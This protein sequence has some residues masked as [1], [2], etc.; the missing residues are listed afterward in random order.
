MRVHPS[1]LRSSRRLWLFAPV[2]GACSLGIFQLSLSR[3]SFPGYSAALIAQ[4][5]GLVPPSGAAHPVFSLLARQVAALDVL[6]LP[7]RLNFF[8][9]LCGSLCA[10]LLCFLVAKLVLYA[11]SEDGGGGARN[12]LMDADVAVPA[13]QPEVV[14]YNRRVFKIALAG[15]FVAA[16][17]LTF[18]TPTWSAST[19]LES[20]MF[21]L[22]LA[23]AAIN[24][25]P[26]LESDAKFQRLSLMVF[27]VALG[28]A[29]TAAFLLLLPFFAYWVFHIF[30]QT[31]RRSV[32]VKC[33]L[34]AGVA[35]VALAV[36]ACWSNTGTPFSNRGLR[37]VLASL[38]RGFAYHHWD[39]LQ[40]FFPRSGW[41]LVSIQVM[42]PAA[43]LLFGQEL[44]F[45]QRRARTL[46][47]LFL[48]ALM[49]LPTLLNLSIA[50][51]LVFQHT[52][53]LP[54]FGA[55]LVAAAVA[56]SAA[57]CLVF[58]GPN[59]MLNDVDLSLKRDVKLQRRFMVMH[60]IACGL[61]PVILLLALVVPW[62]SFRA[63]DARRG[64]FA[65]MFARELL[66][67]MNGR[68]WLVSNGYLD[69][70]L[71]VQADML[72]QPLVLVTLRRQESQRDREPLK[73]H[74]AA[75]PLFN[76]HN[77]QRL[78]NA[79]SIGTVRFLM[80]WF[81]TDADAGRNAMV[82]TTPD[83]WTA[84]GYRAVP[85]GLAFGGI[86]SEQSPEL[87]G[88]V[89]KNKAF[90]ARLLPFLERQGTEASYLTA[91][92]EML[93][94]KAGLAVNELG[95]LL[96]EANESES[97]YQA[98]GRANQIDPLNISA[99]I[100]VYALVA[101]KK[102]HPEML[103]VLKKRVRTVLSGRKYQTQG[104]VGIVQNYG[105]VRQKAFYRQQ[106]A[107]WL[108][109]GSSEVAVEKNK[110]ALALSEQTGAAAMV[111]NASFYFQAGDSDKAES[112]YLSALE[113]DAS[114]KEALAGISMLMALKQ[115]AQMAE[116]WLKRALAAGVD[117]DAVLY[118]T[119]KLALLKADTALA[120]RMLKEATAK[121]PA[122]FRYWYLYADI[123]LRQGD[124]QALE[125]E[126]LPSMQEAL[127]NPNHFVIQ[128][129]RGFL[130]RSKGPK[131]YKEAR[132]SLF[133]AL[134]ANAA[135]PDVWNAILEI[136]MALNDLT[137]MEADSQKLL[138]TEADHA[139]AN[140]L[141]GAALIRRGALKESE[142]FLRRSIETLPTAVAY[143]DLAENLRLQTKPWEAERAA[144]Q[145]LSLTPNL[146]PALD[147]L[148]GVLLDLGKCEESAQLAARAVAARPNYMPY[149]LTLLRAEVR[150][151]R[152]D[153]VRQRMKL[154]EQAKFAIPEDLK[155]EVAALK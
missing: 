101:V 149:Q 114:N 29:D 139:L 13:L 19:R 93:R 145:A 100:N 123:L 39:E 132:L 154:F 146:L 50:P 151:G 17:L 24:L 81:K 70:H 140:Y 2:A 122:D 84:C 6:S 113:I 83:L 36:Y 143:N 16:Y 138:M 57:A 88:I 119:I 18:L 7:V 68:T 35:G 126:V 74:I 43:V 82:F 26:R 109:R 108:T 125:F 31:E 75:D 103:D 71:V 44:L 127:K 3:G 89:E 115:D 63:V 105:T 91:L 14:I 54:V 59:D 96:D 99:A 49:G 147:T 56:F 25:C 48:A 85:E 144:R 112:C 1:V 52:D 111:E 40:G 4:A 76:G 11:A 152:K 22:L 45:K 124:K 77:R 34:L 130:L 87:K 32:L 41:L 128:A 136:D 92:R 37:S 148:A 80:E 150:L 120:L 72:K 134:S 67:A 12:D 133:R 118:Q 107:L 64:A 97:A 73:R 58:T 131:F 141:M 30:W 38:A 55:A 104:A 23:L 155:K 47:A 8:A 9:A 153:K 27:L 10:M 142:D 86:R 121:F 94:M 90:V 110:K 21:D 65:D 66:A 60:T 51:F 102:V 20:G 117:K 28:V 137:F 46:T 15:G 61:L 79:L 62:R 69:N 98:Y 53:H 129:I 95:A 42:L 135:L 78:Q 116:R 5:A 33:V 106:S